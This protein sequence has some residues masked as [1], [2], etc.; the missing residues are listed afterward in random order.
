[1][2]KLFATGTAL[3]LSARQASAASSKTTQDMTSMNFSKKHIAC[4]V[5][6]TV[7]SL[8]WGW[9]GAVHGQIGSF[10]VAPGNNY[11][12]RIILKTAVPMCGSTSTWAYVNEADSNYKV[13]SGALLAAKLSGASVTIYSTRD[14]DTGFC[15]IGYISV[16]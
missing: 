14:A 16:A 10:D 2:T 6:S 3:P 5:L 15:H 7:S 11:G 8:A 9:E 4:L 12:V 13:F 1:M